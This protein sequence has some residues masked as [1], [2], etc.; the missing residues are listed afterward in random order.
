[1]LHIS[2]KQQRT[3]RSASTLANTLNPLRPPKKL[4]PF[5]HV[6][7][8]YWF[9]QGCV[10]CKCQ[11][12]QSALLGC[13][14]WVNTSRREENI[15]YRCINTPPSP[16]IVVR[17]TCLLWPTNVVVW[18]HSLST[19]SWVQVLSAWAVIENE[20]VCR[21]SRDTQ[22]TEQTHTTQDNFKKPSM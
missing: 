12:M 5:L 20:N 14:L 2:G 6:G 3:R 16:T 21:L 15:Y 1:M 17:E 8:G 13:V 10:C 11:Q 18:K 19:T 7:R 4:C 9:S 22:H